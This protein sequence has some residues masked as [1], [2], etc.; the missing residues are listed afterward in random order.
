MSFPAKHLNDGEEVV[1]DVHPHWW[2][3]AGPVAAV[4]VAVAGA[5]T[6]VVVGAPAWAA[7]VVAVVVGLS[8]LW[9][10]GRYLRWR[11][12]SFV[13]TNF[14]LID[15][16][17]IPYPLRMEPTYPLDLSTTCPR[18]NSRPYTNTLRRISPK[19]SFAAQ[20]LLLEP[21]SSL[22]RKRMVP[23]VFV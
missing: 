1:I 23:F 16:T 12:T 4:M 11:T 9:L 19:D 6:L 13:C 8:V 7:V 18:L 20:N 21:R 2:Y 22:L 5:L 3:L 10:L 14:R 17:I 15:L